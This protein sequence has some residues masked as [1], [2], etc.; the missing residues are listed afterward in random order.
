MTVRIAQISDLH[1][2]PVHT[3][4]NR[5]A[6]LL[7]E[8]L[9]ASKPDLLLCTGDIAFLG[10]EGNGDLDFA[11]GLLRGAGIDF[12][13]VPGNHDVGE[14]PDFPEKA[15]AKEGS[16]ARYRARAG[17]D[18]WVFDLPGWRF[19]GLNSLIAGSGLPGDAE[20]LA[21]LGSASADRGARKLCVAQHKPMADLS[22]AETELNPRFTT[23]GPRRKILESIGPQPAH[24][25]LS[26]HVHQY[27]D[28]LIGGSRHLWCPAASFIIGDPWQPSYGAKPVG[29]IEHVFHADGQH[30]HKLIAVRGLEHFDLQNMPQ[31]YG[32][33][34]ARGPGNG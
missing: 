22:Y 5:N 33:V 17:A 6:E 30:E 34:T 28:S 29:Y 18:S 15:V 4:F 21:A 31:V 11:L 25:F 32:D 20:Q 24:L 19:S 3:Y 7:I 23:P 14:H 8:A 9:R 1:V 26:G 2:S 16:L 12:R 27:R 10:E 13:L